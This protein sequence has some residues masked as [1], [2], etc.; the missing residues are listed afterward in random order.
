MF[1]RSAPSYDSVIPFFSTFGELLVDIAAIRPNERVLD[2]AAGRG[3]SAFPAA[4]RGAEVVAVDLAPVMVEAL[5]ADAAERG[6]DRLEV[7]IGDAED[8][9]YEDEFDVVLC[10]FALHI[11]PAPDRA[12]AGSL[13]ALRPGGRCAVS[14]PTGGGP[15]WEF[16]ADVVRRSRPARNGRSRLRRG[17]ATCGS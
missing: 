3:A 16:Y 1:G 8:L 12:F 5:R 11:V 6:L 9:R 17:L 4:E 2:V 14:Y 10:G 13:R 7:A 15:G